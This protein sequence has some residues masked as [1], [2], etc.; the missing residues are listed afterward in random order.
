MSFGGYVLFEGVIP[1]ETFVD[2]MTFA[3]TEQTVQMVFPEEL[4]EPSPVVEVLEEATASVTRENQA[5]GNSADLITTINPSATFNITSVTG[6]IASPNPSLTGGLGK[7]TQGG[8]TASG[9]SLRGITSFFGIQTESEGIAFF[10]DFS[11]SMDGANRV[12]L[13]KEFEQALGK[14]PDGFP[15]MIVA[16][17][18]PAWDLSQEAKEVN[19]EWVAKS[20]ASWRMTVASKQKAPEWIK[21]DPDSR[22]W[23]KKRLQEMVQAPGGTDWRSPF[24]LA[25]KSTRFPPVIFLMTDGQFYNTEPFLDDIRKIVS[26]GN[27]EA[28]LNVVGF[29][30]TGPDAEAALRELAAAN[31]GT[32]RKAN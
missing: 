14:L 4:P 15:V 29:G 12:K 23:I 19:K 8:K 27:S 6:A 25:A 9:P 5:T 28:V 26:K 1:R 10:L 11:G 16:W 2:D 30:G 7:S 18:G 32:Y 22:K 31:K 24:V 20:P 17:S 3:S 13:V 21:L